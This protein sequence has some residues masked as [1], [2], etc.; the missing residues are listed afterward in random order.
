[1][2][3]L[4]EERSGHASRARAISAIDERRNPRL[5][6]FAKWC[7]SRSASG[8]HQILVIEIA[9]RASRSSWKDNGLQ[10]LGR[11][12]DRCPVEETRRDFVAWAEE[13]IEATP[14]F[15]RLPR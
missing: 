5:A 3:A 4:T 15:Y 2:K 1:V 6:A 9:S 13:T 7:W 12:Y 10:E 11:L 14:T 8:R